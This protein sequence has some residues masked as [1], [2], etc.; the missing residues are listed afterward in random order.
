MKV[1]EVCTDEACY[2]D[3]LDELLGICNAIYANRMEWD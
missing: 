1:C 3:C 2:F